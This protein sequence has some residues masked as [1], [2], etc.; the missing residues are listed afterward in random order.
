MD[1]LGR[2]VLVMGM[3][4]IVRLDGGKEEQKPYKTALMDM[5]CGQ[6]D[7]SGCPRDTASPDV[8]LMGYWMFKT[9]LLEL[10]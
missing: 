5:F 10:D 2:M 9:P 7:S 1:G 4:L 8:G 6:I 3:I